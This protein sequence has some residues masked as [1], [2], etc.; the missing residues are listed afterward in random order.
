MRWCVVVGILVGFCCVN[1]VL[2]ADNYKCNFEDG[3]LGVGENKTNTK[4]ETKL[5]E[6]NVKEG[7]YSLEIKNSSDTSAGIQVVIN[8]IDKGKQ[9]R[10]S[11]WMKSSEK[12][13]QAFLRIAWYESA[14]ATGSQMKTVDSNKLNGQQDWTKVEVSPV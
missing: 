6:E 11:A 5:T 8:Q 12:T 2:A 13:K 4:V 14:D 1:E 7:K 9:Y 3:S 10:A